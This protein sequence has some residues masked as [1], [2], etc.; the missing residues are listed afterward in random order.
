MGRRCFRPTFC[1][2]FEQNDGSMNEEVA[3]EVGTVALSKC[4]EKD[5][6]LGRGNRNNLWPGN[7][8]FRNLA[9]K[10]REQYSKVNRCQKVEIALK[11]IDEITASGGR[12]VQVDHD[13][14]NSSSSHDMYCFEVDR[15]RSIEKTCQ[16][17]REKSTPKYKPLKSIGERSENIDSSSRNGVDE[18]DKIESR[19]KDASDVSPPTDTNSLPSLFCTDEMLQRLRSFQSKYG[20]P[21][22]P[23]NWSPDI[24]LSD[25]CC[26]QRQLYRETQAGCWSPPSNEEIAPTPDAAQVKLFEDLNAMNFSWDF[27]EWHWNLWY[28]KLVDQD[29]VDRSSPSVKVWVRDQRRKYQTGILSAERAVKLKQAGVLFL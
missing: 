5:V 23:P 24:V 19:E 1:A 21:N 8:H 15:A 28:S 10:Y 9:M 29:N 4:T 20:H 13:A 25:W 26:V 14:Y 7:I 12:F 16:V 2:T 6:L 11:V 22:V 3:D 18:A 17:L 27:E